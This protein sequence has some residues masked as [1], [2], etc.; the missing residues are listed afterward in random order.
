[1]G[2]GASRQSPAASTVRLQALST[3][4]A[5]G[6]VAEPYQITVNLKGTQST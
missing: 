4:A 5:R 1:M 2:S 3:I 6:T